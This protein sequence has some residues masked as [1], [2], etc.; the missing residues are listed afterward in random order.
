MPQAI[1]RLVGDAMHTMRCELDTGVGSPFVDGAA[2]RFA[3]PS[4]QCHAARLRA[5]GPAHAAGLDCLFIG[6]RI[7]HA[8]TF[9]FELAAVEADAHGGATGATTKAGMEG[10]AHG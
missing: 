2:H 8:P 6:Q 5:V 7:R 10:V 1:A 9:R 4:H 3:D